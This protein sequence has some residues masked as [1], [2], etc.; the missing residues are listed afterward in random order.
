MCS[1]GGGSAPKVEKAPVAP[2]IVAPIE[3]DTS[4]ASAGDL[5]RKRRQA[6]TGRSDTIMTGSMGDTSQAKVGGKKLLGE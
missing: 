4:A 1:G 2:S 3:A 5:E 6:A